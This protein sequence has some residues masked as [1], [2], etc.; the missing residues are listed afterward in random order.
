MEEHL[1]AGL[2]VVDLGDPTGEA[3]TRLLADL[4]ATVLTGHTPTDRPDDLGALVRGLNKWHVRRDL[5]D[6]DSVGALVAD[7]DIVLLDLASAAVFEPEALHARHPRLVIVVTS[8]FGRTGPRSSWQ[9]SEPVLLAL[10]KL[11]SGPNDVLFVGDSPHDVESGNAA[12]VRTAAATWGPF[13]RAALARARPTY[14]VD[15][16]RQI[17]EL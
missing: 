10:S 17:L 9:A 8:D 1:L 16:P 11:G 5:T 6:P 13:S 12:G 7:A 3:A 15:H 4:G 14:W 2:R